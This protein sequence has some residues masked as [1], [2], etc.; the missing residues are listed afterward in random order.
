MTA[1]AKPIRLYFAMG[2][3]I[4]AAA[5]IL[6]VLWG[7]AGAWPSQCLGLLRRAYDAVGVTFIGLAPLAGLLAW[8]VMRHV[9]DS[10]RRE[11]L[12][13]HDLGYV[14][15]TAPTL[16]LLGTVIALV[17]AGSALGRQVQ[18]GS[19]EAILEVV[20]RVAEALLSTVLGLLLKWAADSAIHLI[21]RQQHR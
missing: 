14:S 11:N 6:S 21:E 4:G 10:D 20:P 1:L 7:P 16:G 12:T 15:E 2:L 9:T 8:I 5:S 19:A 18:A 3:T 13:I 17:M